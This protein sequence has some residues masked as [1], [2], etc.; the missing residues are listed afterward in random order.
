[1]GKNP[2]LRKREFNVDMKMV[3]KIACS[4]AAVSVL[5]MIGFWDIFH[6]NHTHLRVLNLI[7]K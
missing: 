7:Q 2:R 3:N 5:S 6:L 1:M 4:V